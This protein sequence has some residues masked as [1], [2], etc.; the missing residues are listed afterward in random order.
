MG[1]F[2]RWRT[3]KKVTAHGRVEVSERDGVRRMHLGGD[4]V[5]S[6]MRVNAPDALEIAYTRSMMA[7]LL[8]Q[9]R[10]SDISIVGLG[11]GSTAKWLYRHFPQAQINVVEI[12][13][14]VPPIA[15]AYFYLPLDES[16]LPIHIG[17]GAAYIARRAQ[18]CDLLLVD[19]YDEVALA[20]S[21]A[22]PEFFKD[23][24]SALKPNGVCVMNLWG[25]DPK[26]RHYVDRLTEIFDGLLLCLTAAER[27]NVIA[28]GFE[29]SPN[30]PTWE[31][32]KQRARDLETLHGLEF[33]KFVDDLKKMNLH[34]EKRLII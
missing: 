22:T 14:D 11:G 13:P 24:R 34:N 4:T 1:F 26:F 16:R 6:A 25:S 7:F 19:G 5:Q 32:L 28:L 29:R 33:S 9:S 23:C 3:H 15:R 18:Q 31:D 10:P 8:F 20:P 21:L 27:G 2:A 30:M 12:N 17:D